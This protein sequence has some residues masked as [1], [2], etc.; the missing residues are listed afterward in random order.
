MALYKSEFRFTRAFVKPTLCL[1]KPFIQAHALSVYWKHARLLVS[2]WLVGYKV[3][4]L[5]ML[6]IHFFDILHSVK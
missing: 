1:R 5:S 2:C 3:H 6:T 4:K